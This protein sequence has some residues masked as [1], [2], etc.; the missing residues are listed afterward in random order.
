MSKKLLNEAA[1]RR[2]MGLAGMDANIVSNAVN[3]MYGAKPEGEEHEEKKEMDKPM[4]EAVHDAAEEGAYGDKEEAHCMEEEVDAME[5]EH[6]DAADELPPEPE[7]G[8]LGSELNLDPDT[9]RAI[10][11]FAAQL[12][13]ALGEEPEAEEE[14]LDDAGDLD[15]ELGE[16]VED[17]AL[18]EAA[19]EEMEEALEGV[20]TEL[21]EEE[22]VQE[23]ARRVAARILKAKKAQKEMNE[24]L[25]K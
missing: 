5:G 17:E 14:P 23:V 20:T 11:E 19:T 10:I 7:E 13:A 12:E 3:E 18:E 22:V 15:D 24:A 25:G 1:V 8:S 2:F 9:A 21:T 4:E 6:E 16:P